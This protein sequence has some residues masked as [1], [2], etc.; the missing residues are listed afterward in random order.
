MSTRDQTAIP[1]LCTTPHF[2]GVFR[3]CG[4]AGAPARAGDG[5][6]LTALIGQL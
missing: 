4:S 3:S 2:E 6:D 5:E 1:E